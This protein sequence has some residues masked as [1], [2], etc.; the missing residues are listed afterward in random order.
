[1]E[2]NPAR[3]VNC[4]ARSIALF[5]SLMARGELDDAMES[6]QAFLRIIRNS[7]YRPNLKGEYSRRKFRLVHCRTFRGT[8]IRASRRTR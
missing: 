4:Q 8:L 2:F 1:M 7:N 3:S 5:L 6:A